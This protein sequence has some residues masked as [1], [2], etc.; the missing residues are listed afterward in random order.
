MQ[1]W[2][3]WKRPFR[4]ILSHFGGKRLEKLWIRW[5]WPF[6]VILR[7]FSGKRLKSCESG[8][9]GHS[10]SFRATSVGKIGE[11]VNRA[12]LAIASHSEPLQ[13][14][15]LESLQ[16]RWNWPFWVILSHFGGKRLEKLQ[17]GQN[18]PFQVILRH[19]GGKDWKSCK[20]GKIGHSE[21]FW[22]TSVGKDWKSYK[23][24]EIGHS[25]SFWATLVG[26]FGKV[27]TRTK[28]NFSRGRG[29]HQPETQCHVDPKFQLNLKNRCFLFSVFHKQ[30]SHRA[31]GTA[32]HVEV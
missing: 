10:Q 20:L 31:Y 15:R 24:G 13:W 17:I 16:V 3:D 12:K 5:N 27:A 22:A 1:N 26:K 14:K 8:E 4:I 7:Y 29:L 21:S 11:V 2:K 9:I 25:E 32:V 23:S 18:W 28:S 6:Q 19:F 30:W